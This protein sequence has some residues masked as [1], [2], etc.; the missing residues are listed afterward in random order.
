M[1]VTYVVLSILLGCG[2][3]QDAHRFGEI[4]PDC[5][6][7]ACVCR[8]G[9]QSRGTL[10]R[11]TMPRVAMPARC[12]AAGICP[13]PGAAQAEAS[14][15][16]DSPKKPTAAGPQSLRHTETARKAFLWRKHCRQQCDGRKAS[17][18]PFRRLKLRHRH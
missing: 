10:S 13:L 5:G 18:R 17:R 12:K 6:S 9:H 8:T 3:Q 15:Q 11:R 1:P 4:P 2:V 7:A 16:Q 14:P